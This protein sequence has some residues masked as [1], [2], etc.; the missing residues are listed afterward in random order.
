MAPIREFTRD[1]EVCGI[2]Y[3]VRGPFGWTLHG[4]TDVHEQRCRCTPG[5][6]S[7]WRGF[8]FNRVAELCRVCGCEV[9][10]SGSKFSI[11][12]CG[13]CKPRVRAVS[14]RLGRLVVPVGRHSIVNGFALS[15]E[16]ETSDEAIEAFA[17]RLQL[18]G[19][20]IERL[21]GWAQSVVRSNLAE[22]GRGDA[23][24]VPLPDYL[25]AVRDI[26]RAVAFDAMLAWM[27]GQAA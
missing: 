13:A 15:V 5:T 8:D 16:P 27:A 18:M 3:D 25:D 23:A 9:L 1:F 4:V 2:C 20:R 12:V 11:W 6:G 21:D 26:D 10:Q 7:T 14:A 17:G 19:G 22:I 24:S